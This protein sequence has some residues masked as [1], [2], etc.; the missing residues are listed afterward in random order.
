MRTIHAICP[1][2]PTP[3]DPILTI[4]VTRRPAL[5]SME[6]NRFINESIRPPHWLDLID[7]FIDFTDI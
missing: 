2:I 3:T 6:I 5:S 7:Y 1:K 4:F